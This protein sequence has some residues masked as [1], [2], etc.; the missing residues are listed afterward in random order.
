MEIEI[1]S[2][3]M[4]KATQNDYAAYH[5]IRKDVRAY[6]FPDDPPMDDATFETLIESR[7]EEGETIS[8]I[9][10]DK[11]HHE[12]LVALARI[13]FLLEDSPS[14]EGN[15]HICRLSG[16]VV[17]PQYQRKGVAKKLLESIVKEALSRKMSVLVGSIF[18]EGGKEFLR[19]LGGKSALESREY[20]LEL[21]DVDWSMVEEWQTDGKACSPDAEIKFTTQIPESILERYCEV[22]TEVLNQA[23]RDELEVGDTVL[24]ADRWRDDHQRFNKQGIVHLTAYILESNGDISGL[25]DVYY[26]PS[27]VPLLSQALTGVQEEYRGYGRG[28]WLK[29]AMLLE[30]KNR[31]QDVETI[32]TDNATSN[33]PMLAINERLGFKLS[34]EITS[35]QVEIPKVKQY[36]EMS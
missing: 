18:N 6:L 2:L 12:N 22:Y 3:D 16:P 19:K 20:R 15:E 28:K 9:A 33:E 21:S 36:L 17:L 23:P 35:F 11:E 14:Y 4:R 1:K 26:V 13:Y 31:F 27:M 25:T 34:K 10:I 7:L 29:A 24:T 8:Y 5:E 32:V 30:I